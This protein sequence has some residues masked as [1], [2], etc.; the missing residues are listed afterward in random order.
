[1]I[2]VRNRMEDEIG[3][4]PWTEHNLTEPFSMFPL[5]GAPPRSPLTPAPGAVEREGTREDWPQMVRIE[6]GEF[7]MGSPDGEGG[8]QERREPGRFNDELRHRIRIDRDFLIGKTEVTQ[9]QWSALLD[10]N[11]SYFTEERGGGAG[12][13]GRE[14]ELG[15]R[16]RLSQRALRSMRV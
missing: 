15:G 1:M 16:R 14:C 5:P 6:A 13:P 4:E 9:R 3:Q 10:T 12:S 7:W 11:P 2:Y 8:T